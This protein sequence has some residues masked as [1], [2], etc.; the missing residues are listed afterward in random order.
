[1]AK[2]GVRKAVC[3][4]SFD[5]ITLGHQDIVTKGLKVFDEIIIGIGENTDKKYMFS[6]EKR[7]AWC[8]FQEDHNKN[9]L[10]LI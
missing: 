3:P 8:S 1:M 7:F 10:N 9:L 6:S 5:P 4:G 2:S